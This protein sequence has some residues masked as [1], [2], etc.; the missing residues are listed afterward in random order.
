MS[1]QSYKK[2]HSLRKEWEYIFQ[3]NHLAQPPDFVQEKAGQN[4]NALQA[5]ESLS[6]RSDLQSDRYKYE[7]L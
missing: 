3:K 1:R 4:I 5:V 2:S 6:A 7:H